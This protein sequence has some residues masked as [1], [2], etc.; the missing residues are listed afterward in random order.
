MGSGWRNESHRH[1]LAGMGISTSEPG[2]L[3]LRPYNIKN[4]FYHATDSEPFSKFTTDEVW[5]DVAPITGYGD[6]EVEVE[7]NWSRPFVT[8]TDLDF[9]GIDLDISK[10]EISNNRK[11]YEKLGGESNPKTF[12]WLRENGYDILI[13][14]EG[15]CALYPERVI[16][17]EW[18]PEWGRQR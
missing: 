4:I 9:Y 15:L 16:I 12:D 7:Y 17:R 3:K 14:S 8:T 2:N 11:I 1:R 18:E 10:E 13:D 6:R 5:F